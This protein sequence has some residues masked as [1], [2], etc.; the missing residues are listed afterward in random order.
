[1]ISLYC[2]F[3][4]EIALVGSESEDGVNKPAEL[5][6]NFSSRK[7]GGNIELQGRLKEQ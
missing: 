6:Y 5:T 4:A 2:S 3:I 7:Y 1:M